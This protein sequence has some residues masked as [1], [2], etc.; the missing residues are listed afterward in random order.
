MTAGMLAHLQNMNQDTLSYVI[1][2][3][4]VTLLDAIAR[5]LATVYV[6][7]FKSSYCTIMAMD[8][9]YKVKQL[10]LTRVAIAG[11]VYHDLW[12]C[13]PTSG[14]SIEQKINV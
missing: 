8:M 9:S 2:I 1:Q 11:P 4:Y 13:L 6:S 10:T 12:H 3:I 14:I 5:F 7:L